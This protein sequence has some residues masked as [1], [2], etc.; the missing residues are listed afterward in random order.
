MGPRSV[1]HWQCLLLAYFVKL[2]VGFIERLCLIESDGMSIIIRLH[3]KWHHIND[4]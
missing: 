4:Q 2:A 3:I 1:K